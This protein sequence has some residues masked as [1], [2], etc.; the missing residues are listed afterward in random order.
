M[1]IIYERIKKGFHQGI[2]LDIFSSKFTVHICLYHN[3]YWDYLLSRGC[4]S[5]PLIGQ[6]SRYW[7]LIGRGQLAAEW[8]LECESSCC[9]EVKPASHSGQM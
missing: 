5:W 2:S 4:L 7:P 8:S 9:R 1:R 6:M 3:S